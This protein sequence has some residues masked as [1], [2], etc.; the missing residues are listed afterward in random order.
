MIDY[1][2]EKS[3][4]LFELKLDNIKV[5]NIDI[6][7]VN[8]FILGFKKVTTKVDQIKL[9]KNF[10]HKMIFKNNKKLIKENEMLKLKNVD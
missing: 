2:K 5:Y 6:N 1:F 7:V 3:I 4:N 9:F 8:L 10:K